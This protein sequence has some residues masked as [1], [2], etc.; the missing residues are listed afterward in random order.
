MVRKT[1]IHVFVAAE[2][3]LYFLVDK[4]HFVV[5]IVRHLRVAIIVDDYIMVVLNYATKKKKKGGGHRLC[6]GVI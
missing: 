2:Q 3:L 6:V 1:L 5:V 4:I